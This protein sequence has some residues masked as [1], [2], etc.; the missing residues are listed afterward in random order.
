M[1]SSRR[2]LGAA[3]LA[4]SLL[5]ACDGGEPWKTHDISGL[6]PDLAFA[7]GDDQGRQVG[8]QDYHGKVTLLFFGY[9]H[10][11]DVCQ[12]TLAQLAQTLRA[13]G[14]GRDDVR[15]LFVTVDPARDTTAIMRDY[16]HAFGPQFVGLRGERAAIDALARRYRVAYTL[17]KPDAQG[18][19]EVNHGSAVF[20]FGRDGEARLVF[21]PKDAP[22]AM[23][24]DL[25]RVIFE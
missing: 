23:A 24:Q 13:S 5:A 9:T 7:L 16:V 22:D 14:G 2:W 25:R 4:C 1:L 11:P 17:G 19:Y 10:C 6:V 18:N 15:V 3:I 20:V 21:T 12:T 8:A